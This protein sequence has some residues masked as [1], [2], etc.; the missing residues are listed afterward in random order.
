MRDGAGAGGWF[1]VLLDAQ[2]VQS[3]SL[4]TRVNETASEF[5]GMNL[6]EAY[7]MRGQ[8]ECPEGTDGAATATRLHGQWLR[9]SSFLRPSVLQRDGAVEDELRVGG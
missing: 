4:Q 5:N 7:A 9:L 8:Q 1:M 6:A 2:S 3:A